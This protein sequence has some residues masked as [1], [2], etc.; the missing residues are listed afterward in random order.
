MKKIA[1]YICIILLAIK[2]HAKAD[3]PNCNPENYRE[4]VRCAEKILLEIK[5]SD[6]QLKSGQQLEAIA[7][8]WVNPELDVESVRKGSEK[9][10]TS[11]TLFFNLRLGGKQ[12]ALVN[13]AQSQI[14]KIKAERDFSV[15]R[16]RL[17]FM[18]KTY[19]LSHLKTEIEITKETVEIYSK[20]TNQ[21]SHRVSLTPEQD[22]SLSVFIMALADQKLK[23][24]KLQSDERKIYQDIQTS[25][26]LPKEIISKNLP[27]KKEN[28]PLISSSFE[29]ENSP[30]VRQ[31]LAELNIAKAQKEKAITEAWPDLKIGPTFKTTQE[32]G[33]SSTLIG[34]GLSIPLPILTQNNGQRAYTSMRQTESEM[35]LAQTKRKLNAS[36]NELAERYNQIV[37]NLKSSLSSKTIAKKHKQLE[38]QFFKGLIPSSLVIEAHRQFQEFEEN[39]NSSEFEALEALGQI[40]IADDQFNE[41]TL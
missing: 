16:A 17:D 25:L 40:L 21:F 1:L 2:V 7:N 35:L 22:V 24:L 32:N 14:A 20:I 41:V 31:A 36:R 23:L 26:N 28:W 19:R 37:T 9:S 8:E 6:Q 29:P 11:A 18:L 10:E 27:L 30:Q 39:R 34:F 33:E 12:N 4:L 3:A 38:A 5:I 15:N 13:E